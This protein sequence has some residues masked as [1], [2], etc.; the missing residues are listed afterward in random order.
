MSK[1]KMWV[2]VLAVFLCGVL[3][4]AVGGGILVRHKAKAAFE[5]LRTDD[6]SYLTSIMMKGL[7]RELNLTDKQQK[8]Y[9]SHI[10][11]NPR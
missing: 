3:V 1:L 5:R 7:A 9:P 10:G 4:G 11:E 2:A 6:G 8:R